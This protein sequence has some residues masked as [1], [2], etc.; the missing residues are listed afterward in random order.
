MSMILCVKSFLSASAT[1]NWAI[2]RGL[3]AKSKLVSEQA[4]HPMPTD[5]R[6][7][8]YPGRGED[9]LQG[10]PDHQIGRPPR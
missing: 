6:C 2:K 3:L 9:F 4:M 7:K 10:P 8:V 1:L 5:C